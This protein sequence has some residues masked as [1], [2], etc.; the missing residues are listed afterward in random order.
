MK[1]NATRLLCFLPLFLISF[2]PNVLPAQCSWF[3]SYT[4]SPAPPF[5]YGD[6]ITLTVQAN[7]GTPPFTYAWNDG[8]T[9]QSIQVT[10][11]T[12]WYDGYVNVT[13]ANGC[14]DGMSVHIKP[15]IYSMEMIWFADAVC[16]GQP[17]QVAAYTAGAGGTATYQWSNGG[18]GQTTGVYTSGNYSVTVTAPNGCTRSAS[19]YVDVFHYEPGA[20]QIT[21]PASLCEGQS[22]TLA[23]TGGYYD[24]YSWSDGST[25]SQNPIR[26]PGTYTVTVSSFDGQCTRRPAIIA[27]A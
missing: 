18:T 4:T 24:L 14:S 15:T 23:V 11:N 27:K 17:V 5:C 22:G 8:Q 13:D 10:F 12:N 2:V 1:A 7:G 6:V 26:A 21:G 19:E 16:P 3:A 20:V 25:S 9:T